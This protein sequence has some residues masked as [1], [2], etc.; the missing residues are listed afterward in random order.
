MISFDNAPVFAV[1]GFYLILNY[2]L[3]M[4]MM[5]NLDLTCLIESGV[6]IL[7]RVRC[8]GAHNPTWHF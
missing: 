5:Q 7:V 6:V 3:K 1:D 8:R 4:P 2:N